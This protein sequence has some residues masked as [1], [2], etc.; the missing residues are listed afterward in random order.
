M[1][2]PPEIPVDNTRLADGQVLVGNE[3]DLELPEADE[4]DSGIAVTK[5]QIELAVPPGVL[6][7]AEKIT[8][9]D[10]IDA[11]VTAIREFIRDGYI[12]GI[13]PGNVKGDL[14]L[15]EIYLDSLSLPGVLGSLDEAVQK[16]TGRR[17]SEDALEKAGFLMDSATKQKDQTIADVSL[18]ISKVIRG[19]VE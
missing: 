9:K 1:Q 14:P 16:R 18:A 11:L 3:A 17:M 15:S 10:I 2:K 4:A 12:N 6:N 8:E 7:P 19:E 13:D 5:G